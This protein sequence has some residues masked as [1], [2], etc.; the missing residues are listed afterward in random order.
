MAK[1]S[2]AGDTWRTS[3]R[4][5][6]VV[7][8]S[9]STPRAALPARP[10]RVCVDRVVRLRDVHCELH[11]RAACS[12]MPCTA[13]CP[14]AVMMA[15]ADARDMPG[16]RQGSALLAPIDDR[17]AGRDPNNESPRRCRSGNGRTC[18]AADVEAHYTWLAALP[19][20]RQVDDRLRP[21]GAAAGLNA[22]A[23]RP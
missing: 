9:R 15:L 19:P 2:P 12:S 4:C 23:G 14:V 3:H 18:C 21:I 6:R 8:S 10:S 16:W 13:S 17:D 7:S 22:L 20:H 5:P 11:R 1:A